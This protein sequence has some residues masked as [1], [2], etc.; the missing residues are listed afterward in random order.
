MLQGG[1]RRAL[2]LCN[3]VLGQ[4]LAELNAPLVEG[5]NLPDG[6]LGKDRMLVERDQLAQRFRREPLRQNYIR[7]A[8]ALKDAMGNQ[9]V[10][11]SLGP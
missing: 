1:I 5:V 9:P 4:D 10:R 7:G 2:D 8:V 11:R 6:A 3:D